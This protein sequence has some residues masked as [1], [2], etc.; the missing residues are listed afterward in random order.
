MEER[1]IAL[2]TTVAFYEHTIAKLNEFVSEQQVQL[3]ALE[4]EVRRLTEQMRSLGATDLLPANEE[5]PPPHY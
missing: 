5:P 3:Q 2:E 1:I 4:V